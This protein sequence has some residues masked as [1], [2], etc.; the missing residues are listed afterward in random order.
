ML[1]P[2]VVRI[3]SARS[4]VGKTRL[5]VALVKRITSLGYRVAVVKHAAHG[6]E[7][8]DK[9]TSLYV[10]A[11]AHTV[12]ASSPS[13]LAV[14]EKDWVDDLQQALNI[15]YQPIIIVEGYRG[16]G[17]G[18]VVVVASTPEEAEKLA[19]TEKNLVAIV[20]S[21]PKACQQAGLAGQAPV[22][23]FEDVD[24]L[25]DK[26]LARAREHLLSQL[27]R[28]DCGY[29][30]YTSCKALVEAYMKGQRCTCPRLLDVVLEVEGRIVQL[31]PFVKNVV[32][33]VIEALASTLKGVPPRRKKIRV[34]VELA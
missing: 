16:V 14:Y 30:G 8:E 5:G 34:E 9:D 17:I 33:S 11:G 23:G 24:K 13:L 29:C 27:P 32:K 4:G 28:L 2:Y 26:L 20:C 25:A 22:M 31:N 12:I 15:L 21:D 1:K 7:L 10:T 6:L 19:K 18:D 3:V